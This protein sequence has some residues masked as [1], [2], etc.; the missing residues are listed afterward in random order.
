VPARLELTS[1][2]SDPAATLV[3]NRLVLDCAVVAA[4][5]RK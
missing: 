2:A 5:Y 4:R 1:A 3:S